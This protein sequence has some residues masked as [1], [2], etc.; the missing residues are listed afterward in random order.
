MDCKNNSVVT[1]QSDL[2]KREGWNPAEYLPVL[3]KCLAGAFE[4]K[5]PGFEAVQQ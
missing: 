4:G 2:Q 1:V 5:A 3:E